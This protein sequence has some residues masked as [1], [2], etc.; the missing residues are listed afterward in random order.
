VR[1]NKRIVR[2]VERIGWLKV[3][4]KIAV[5]RLQV[6]F[7]FLLDPVLFLFR[8]FFFCLLRILKA[9]LLSL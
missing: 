5:G 2:P 7:A 8:C 9:V 1:E 6:K 3:A 4:R